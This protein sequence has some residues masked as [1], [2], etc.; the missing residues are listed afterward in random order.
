MV[1]RD[2]AIDDADDDVLAEQLEVRVQPARLVLE[3]EKRR[4]VVRV[5]MLIGVEPDALRL[6]DLCASR[7][8]SAAVSFAAKPFSA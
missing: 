8:A 3:A 7:D 2:T 4:A 1:R 5:E 6:R